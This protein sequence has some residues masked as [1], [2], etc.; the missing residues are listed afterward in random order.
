MSKVRRHLLAALLA[1][2]AFALAGP[3]AAQAPYPSKPIRMIVGFPGGGITDVISR[4]VANQLTQVLGQSVFI[5]NKPGA[6]TTIAADLVAKSVPDGYTLMLTDVTTHAINASLYPSLPYDTVTSFTPVGM[7]ASTPL[8]LVVNSSSP[9][10]TVQELIAQQKAKPGFYGSSGNGTIIHLAGA[11]LS[12]AGKI[13][14]SHVPYKGSAPATQALLAGEIDFFFSSLPPA[15][16]QVK[17]GKLRALAV[18]TPQRVPSAPDVPTMGEAGVPKFDVV[19]Y[20]GIVGPAGLPAPVVKTLN[21]ALAKVLASPEIKAAYLQ[22][23]ADVVSTATPAQFNQIVAREMATYGPIVKATGA[24][25][26]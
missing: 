23:G 2:L 20:N 4:A 9:V 10:K 25:I 22:L 15:L 14:P 12:S 8:M 19:L 1:P 13:D 16:A 3:S 6:G 21:D 11:M 7:V 18:T 26:E 5:E 24:K 17:A